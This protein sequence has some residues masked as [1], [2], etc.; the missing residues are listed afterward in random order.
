MQRV[1]AHML[2]VQ[3]S[4]QLLQALLLLTTQ[5]TCY[6]LCLKAA[7]ADSVLRIENRAQI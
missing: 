2:H 4:A 5:R 3:T 7:A 6:G 1:V